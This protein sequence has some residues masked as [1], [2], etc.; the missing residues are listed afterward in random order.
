MSTP[1]AHSAWRWTPC[2]GT[3]HRSGNTFLS[4]GIAVRGM[5]CRAGYLKVKRFPAALI[6]VSAPGQVG[7]YRCRFTGN[8][9]QST[10]T[11]CVRRATAYRFSSLS[12]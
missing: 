12:D 8:G 3:I 5:S 1:S 9:P 11:V 2:P 4:D 6:D 7:G 10:E